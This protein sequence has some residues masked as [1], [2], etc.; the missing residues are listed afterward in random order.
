MQIVWRNPLPPRR[1]RSRPRLLELDMDATIYVAGSPDVEAVFELI[2]GRKF[3]N[4]CGAQ[5]GGVPTCVRE[6]WSLSMVKA[7]GA[8]SAERRQIGGRQA[9]GPHCGFSLAECR[10]SAYF[11]GLFEVVTVLQLQR[12]RRPEC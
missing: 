8:I 9:S 2:R 5:R 11:S 7:T 12:K 6:S 3:R 10:A 4:R 1:S